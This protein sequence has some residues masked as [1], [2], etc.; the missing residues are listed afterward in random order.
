MR[1][2]GAG[3]TAWVACLAM[4]LIGR[5]A[6]AG[7]WEPSVVAMEVVRKQYDY[8]LPWTKRM[9]TTQ[10][11][12]VVLENRQILT[13]ADEMFDRTLVRIQKGGRGKWWTGDVSWIDYHANLAL[14]TARE[15]EFW[16]DLKP[17]QL[18]KPVG[19]PD[20]IQ[21]VR[22]REGRMET[23]RAEFNQF[24]VGEGALSFVPHL[25]LE[26]NSEIKG[27]GWGEPVVS[28]GSVIGLASG[29]DGNKATVIPVSF[30]GPILEAQKKGEFRGLGYFDFFW[31]PTENPAVHSLLKLEGPP[32]GVVVTDVPPRL[33]KEP[34]LKPR[35][36]LLEVDGF[37]IDIEGDYSDPDYGHLM[38]ENL[39]TRGKW[40][41][42]SVT[43]KV[44]RDG[45]E[46]EL[47]YQ[48]PKADYS[49]S[50][51]PDAVYDEEPEYLVMGGLVFQPLTDAFLR[52]WG[53]DWKRRSPFRLYY[54]NNQ[55]A[56]PDRPSLVLMSQVLPDVYNIGYQELK[57]LVV[58][59]VNGRKITKLQEVQEA[60]SKPESGVHVIDFMESDSLRRVVVDAVEGQAATRRVLQRYGIS[61]PFYFAP[62]PET[63]VVAGP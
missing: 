17:V 63:K 12:G 27:I 49:T 20:P 58:D 22:W 62:K 23:R 16:S 14:V 44:W 9:K 29:F 52:G 53:P 56:T 35:D 46:Q 28:G 38:L 32:R 37:A 43:I 8:F 61:K 57:Y 4:G 36:L 47:V 34:V 39:A 26:I 50:L 7:A 24:T 30:I 40:A 48:L 15:G 11:V 51:V 33:G 19:N 55:H 13:T 54:Y 2:I 21:I 25:Q 10:K 1:T 3:L 18:V 59:A 5:A 45:K 41:G 31:Q 42:D 6:E 60:L